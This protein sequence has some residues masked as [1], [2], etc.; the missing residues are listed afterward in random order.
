MDTVRVVMINKGKRTIGA[1]LG[2]FIIIIWLFIV[3]SV[4]SGLAQD[5]IKALVYALAYALGNFVGVTLEE[6]LAIGLS[7]VQVIVRESEGYRLANKLRTKGF[8]VTILH[9]DAYNYKRHI[10]IVHTKRRNVNEAV[11][12]INCEVEDAVITITDTRSVKG[13]FLRRGKIR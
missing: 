1:V 4:M 11:K 3:S 7:T 6:K 5:P 8:G 10:L 12:L 9:G 13:G 2:F